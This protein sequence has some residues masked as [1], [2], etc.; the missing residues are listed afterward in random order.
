MSK[1]SFKFEKTITSYDSHEALKADERAFWHSKTPLERL[2]ALE[3]LRQTLYGYDP[4]T[5]RVQRVL[6]V[7]ELERGSVP[8]RGR[9]RR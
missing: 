6:R 7:L 9:I 1:S 3:I 2:E 5:A 8:P 4:A